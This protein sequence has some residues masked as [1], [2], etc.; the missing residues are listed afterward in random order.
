MDRTKSNHSTFLGGRGQYFYKQLTTSFD[1]IDPDSIATTGGVYK[2]TIDIAKDIYGF[3][4]ILGYEYIYKK[5]SFQIFTGL[6]VKYKLIRQ[7]NRY[8]PDDIY[9]N[10][11]PDYSL[12]YDIYRPG[13]RLS[14]NLPLNLSVSLRL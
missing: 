1:F 9:Y 4:F 8:N 13:Q 14:L 10:R 5:W 3:N 6:G 12:Y 7:L 2:D 11:H